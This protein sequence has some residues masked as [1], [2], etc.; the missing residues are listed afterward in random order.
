MG[1]CFRLKMWRIW[2]DPSHSETSHT[3]LL[4]LERMWE[5]SCSEGR[6]ERQRRGGALGTGVFLLETIWRDPALLGR[7]VQLFSYRTETWK[8][9]VLGAQGTG[10]FLPEG[11]HEDIPDLLGHWSGGWHGFHTRQWQWLSSSSPR[12]RMLHGHRK[13]G[14]SLYSVGTGCIFTAGIPLWWR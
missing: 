4:L 2:S 12:S 11:T 5:Y 10:L 8:I 14:P 7:Q 6:G 13:L 9:S 1:F 3:A